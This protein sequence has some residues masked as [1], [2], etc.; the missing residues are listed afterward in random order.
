MRGDKGGWKAT[1][2]QSL[3]ALIL[4]VATALY[5]GATTPE[6]P[7]KGVGLVFVAFAWLLIVFA[8]NWIWQRS[9]KKT[10][11]SR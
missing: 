11:G 2:G 4:T 10:D 8:A 6:A 9:R 1:G 7:L 5:F 3:L